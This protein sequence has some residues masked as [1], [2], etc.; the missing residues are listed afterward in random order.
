MLFG[1]EGIVR[2]R[3]KYISTPYHNIVG[4]AASNGSQS[5]GVE[6]IATESQDIPSGDSIPTP[7]IQSPISTEESEEDPVEVGDRVMVRRSSSTMLH[8][9]VRALAVD[10]SSAKVM[11]D[12]GL[13]ESNVDINRIE[14]SYSMESGVS[15]ASSQDEPAVNSEVLCT[16]D[17]VVEEDMAK[18]SLWIENEESVS[19]KVAEVRTRIWL[20]IPMY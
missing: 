1:S 17:F 13:V 16:E 15:A 7:E 14:R 9:V 2:L 6:N 4:K 12:N 19:V 8:G 11:Y 5:T 3:I 18:L 10:G 20:G